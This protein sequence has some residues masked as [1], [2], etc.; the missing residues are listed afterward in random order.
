MRK[1]LSIYLFIITVLIVILY[2]ALAIYHGDPC[3]STGGWV[4][5]NLEWGG[6]LNQIANFIAAI[7]LLSAI[8]MLLRL[9]KRRSLLI[10]VIILNII[11]ILLLYNLHFIPHHC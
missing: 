1:N 10:F 9:K 3:S 5:D 4:E 8:F 2:F 6:T 11:F 7:V